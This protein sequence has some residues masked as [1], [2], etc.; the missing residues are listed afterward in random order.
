LANFLNFNPT[1]LLLSYKHVSQLLL[2]F[3]QVEII[4]NNSYKEIDDKLRANNHESQEE[5]YCGKV[6]VF[7]WLI[8]DPIA[9]DSIVHDIDPS[10]SGHHLEQVEHSVDDVIKVG[11]LVLP[12]SPSTSNALCFILHSIVAYEGPSV[13]T[14]SRCYC[15]VFDAVVEHSLKEADA[16]DSKDEDKQE[17]NEEHIRHRRQRS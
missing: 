12:N 4:Y 6:S 7:L 13:N 5:Y 10:F 3:D 17:T 11:I 2:F 1:S 8:S 14:N 15:G 16:H 9:V